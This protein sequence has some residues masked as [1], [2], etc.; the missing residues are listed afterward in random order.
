VIIQW[1]FQDY[2]ASSSAAQAEALENQ[3]VYCLNKVGFGG[4]QKHDMK[5]RNYLFHHT[6]LFR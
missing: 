3:V 4:F 6:I 2:F 5:S 1:F